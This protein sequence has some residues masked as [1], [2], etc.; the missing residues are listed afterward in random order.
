MPARNLNFTAGGNAQQRPPRAA[1]PGATPA[2]P[3]APAAVTPAVAPRPGVPPAVRPNIDPVDVQVGAPTLGSFQE[4]QDAAYQQATRSLDPQWEANSRRFE[5]DMINRGLQPGSEA[6]N[7]AFDQQQRAK[8]DAYA[9]AQNNALQQG[10]AAQQQAFQ[11]NYMESELAN[12]LLRQREGNE[13]SIGIAGLGTQASMYG[14]DIGR[15]NFMDQMGFNQQQADVSAN[16]WDRQ[17]GLGQQNSDFGQYMQMLGFDRDTTNMN[18]QSQNQ[19]FA[20]LMSMFGMM[21]QPQ[22][23]NPVDYLGALGMNQ[24]QQNQNYATGTANANQQNSNYMAAL[25]YLFCD[26]NAKTIGDSVPTEKCLDVV[27]ALPITEFAYKTRPDVPCVGTTAQAFNAALHGEPQPLIK[28]VDLLGVLIGAVQQLSK[29][30]ADQSARL[31]ALEA[32]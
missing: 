21:P 2:A 13:T 29:Q 27:N 14:A 4:H 16:Q 6:Y 23:S 20:Q 1:V 7:L 17:F 19:G 30:Y 8:T 3:G 10:Q 28:V 24:N 18:N 31:A 9:T 12:Q 11:Q 32:S 26:E 25:G 15:L 5:Q 22:G